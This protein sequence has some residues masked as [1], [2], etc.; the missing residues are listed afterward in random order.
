LCSRRI[1]IHSL[2]LVNRSLL[3]QKLLIQLYSANAVIVL[4]SVAAF[5]IS[6]RRANGKR[7]T[8]GDIIRSATE[9]WA[10]SLPRVSI[11]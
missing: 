2:D 7:G 8:I 1:L 11:V 10:K 6:S 3:I 5:E 9:E 4:E